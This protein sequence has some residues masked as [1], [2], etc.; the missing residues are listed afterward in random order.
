MFDDIMKEEE[1][2]LIKVVKLVGTDLAPLSQE[3][4]PIHSVTKL[5]GTLKVL[6]FWDHIPPGVEFFP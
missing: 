1:P 6:S 3:Q 5:L 4:T 2:I